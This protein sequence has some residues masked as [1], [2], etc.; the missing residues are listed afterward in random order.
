M[1]AQ[2][3]WNKHKRNRGGWAIEVWPFSNVRPRTTA[4]H[5]PRRWEVEPSGYVS[6][7]E[8]VVVELS[9][10]DREFEQQKAAFKE[11]PPLILAQYQGQFVVSLN[12]EIVDSDLHLPTLTNRFINVHGDVPVY[13]T[14][15]GGRQ[16]V[17]LR[18]PSRR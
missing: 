10:M 16:R 13:I 9:E 1:S 2:F 12:G 6:E 3:D 11:I 18:T 8:L 7:G 17:L 15:V 4:S 14:K 5:Q